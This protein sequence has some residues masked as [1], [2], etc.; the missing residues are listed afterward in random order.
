[1]CGRKKSNEFSK[2]MVTNVIILN[3]RQWESIR[4]QMFVGLLHIK[5]GECK[6]ITAL[7]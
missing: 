3:I 1:M 7:L 2:E 5:V 4:T 6:R